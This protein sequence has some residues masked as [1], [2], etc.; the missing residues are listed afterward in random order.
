MWTDAATPA[1]QDKFECTDRQMFR[2]AAVQDNKINLADLVDDVVIT[3]T[4]K[5]FP[6]RKPG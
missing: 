5:S 4:M 2:H 6:V 1:L 3:K